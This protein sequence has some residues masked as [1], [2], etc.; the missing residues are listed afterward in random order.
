MLEILF[1][2]CPCPDLGLLAV[3]DS[4][5]FFLYLTNSLTESILSQSSQ[6]RCR[7]LLF[8]HK[9]GEIEV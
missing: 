7:K 2:V 3:R 1:A 6:S 8:Q 4:R 5:N 9:E